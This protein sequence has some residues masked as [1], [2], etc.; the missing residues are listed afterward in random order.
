MLQSQKNLNSQID[1]F[2]NFA[3]NLGPLAEASE[4]YRKSQDKLR[5]NLEKLQK[6]DIKLPEFDYFYSLKKYGG[7]DRRFAIKKA[8]NMALLQ[9]IRQNPGVLSP[10]QEEAW[11]ACAHSLEFTVEAESVIDEII[12]SD[13]EKLEDMLKDNLFVKKLKDMRKKLMNTWFCQ[14]RGCPTCE[15][16]TWMV[17]AV[18]LKEVLSTHLKN[19]GYDIDKGRD[20]PL[21]FYTVTMENV[22]KEGLRDAIGKLADGARVMSQKVFNLGKR[23]FPDWKF[24]HGFY[25]KLEITYNAE[26]DTYHPHMHFILAVDVERYYRGGYFKSQ[27]DFSNLWKRISGFG[28]VDIRA[29]K[30]LADGVMEIAKY[31]TK[32]TDFF[33][34]DDPYTPRKNGE[35][36]LA[37]KEATKGKQMFSYTGDLAK[38]RKELRHDKRSKKEEMQA[39][40]AAGLADEIINHTHK[41]TLN[42]DHE[43][44]DFRNY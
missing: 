24:V 14:I 37:I 41:M 17:N 23:D 22:P 3:E 26:E 16:R 39:M 18:D 29:V 34:Q 13:P 19:R 25:R 11:I 35:V 30:D 1:R 38:I 8:Q 36:W 20:S 32:S 44:H 42:Y 10:L 33:P 2:Q 6:I 15:W 12:K 5:E 9:V 31:A 28:I 27:K 40:L 7:R 43:N 4:R 21:L